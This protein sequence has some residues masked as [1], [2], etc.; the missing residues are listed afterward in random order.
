[1]ILI[2]N[3]GPLY[4]P[5]MKILGL[6]WDSEDDLDIMI[7]VNWVINFMAI[8]YVLGYKVC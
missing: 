7:N 2:H 1:M 6:E 4:K 8:W 5:I 3:L